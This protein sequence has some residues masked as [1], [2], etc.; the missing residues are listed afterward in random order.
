MDDMTLRENFAGAVRRRRKELQMTQQ[1]VADRLEVTRPI[2]AQVEA[3]VCSPTLDTVER[4][5]RALDC[6]SLAL[7]VPS[8]EALLVS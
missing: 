3:G 5:A 6:P 4:F 7:L 2:V 1:D 8:D